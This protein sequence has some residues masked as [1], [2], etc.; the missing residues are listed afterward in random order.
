[1]LRPPGRHRYVPCAGDT[2]AARRT[3]AAKQM[4]V[5]AY[6]CGLKLTPA[7]RVSTGYP[8]RTGPDSDPLHFTGWLQS[9]RTKE[10]NE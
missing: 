4:A 8:E 1:M 9:Q 7:E 6:H 10:H 5:K 2:P 3:N